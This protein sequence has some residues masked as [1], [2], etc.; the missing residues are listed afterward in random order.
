[1]G[2][3]GPGAPLDIWAALRSGAA[4]RAAAVAIVNGSFGIG[5]TCLDGAPHLNGNR[6]E[7]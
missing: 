7:A 1:M 5:V 4:Q 6:S 2:E 3:A